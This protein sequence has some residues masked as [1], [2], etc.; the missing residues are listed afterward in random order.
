M[1]FHLRLVCRLLL[2]APLAMTGGCAKPPAVSS[3]PH[4]HE[5][6]PPHGGTPVVLGDEVYHVE[7]VRDPAAGLLQAY[8]FDGELEN[9][10]RSS[11][12]SIAITATVDGAPRTLVLQ[13]VAN[14]ATG[15]TVGDTSLFQTQADWLKTTGQFDAVLQSITIRGSTFTDVKFNF[16]KGND[17]D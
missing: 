5:H 17:T 14:P 3:Q 6:H 16:P 8:V 9:F 15:E 2:L 10:I 4:K 7:L 11:V 12:P 13:A 1:T